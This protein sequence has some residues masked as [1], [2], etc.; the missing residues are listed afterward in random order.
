[1]FKILS[2]S[3][4]VI[5]HQT[6]REVAKPAARKIM[7]ERGA[8]ESMKAQDPWWRARVDSAD[9][10]KSAKLYQKNYE[11]T[12]PETLSPQAQNQMWKRAKQLK[13]E[14]TQGMLSRDERHPVKGFEVNG[15]I[16]HVVDE[17]RMRA[18][19]SVE[20]EAAWQKRNSDKISEFKNLMRHLNP[21][22]PN[23]GDVE[24]FRPKKTGIR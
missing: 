18:M 11:H 13:D 3:N 10:A 23:A 16:K 5:Q 24:R 17:E 9:A 2:N 15:A 4:A 14:F 20:R 1:M 21:D 19:R 6:M 12:R 22:D 8:D 7:Q